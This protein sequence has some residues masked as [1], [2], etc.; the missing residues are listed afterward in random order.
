MPRKQYADEGWSSEKRAKRQWLLWGRSPRRLVVV[1]LL[2]TTLAASLG[3]SWLIQGIKGFKDL[4]GPHQQW[5]GVVVEHHEGTLVFT[6]FALRYSLVVGFI[7]QH[8][9]SATFTVNVDADTFDAVP[10]GMLITLDL[11]PQT[12]HVYA[13]ATS[14]NGITWT[15]QPLD[16][17]GNQLRLISWVLVPSGA[18]LLLLGL[19]GLVLGLVGLIDFLGGT[20]TIIGIVIDVVEGSFFRMPCVIVDQ[21]DGV[22][23]VLPLRPVVYE[24]VCEDGGRSQMTFIVSRRLR[25]VRRARRKRASGVIPL[26]SEKPSRQNQDDWSRPEEQQE[27]VQSRPA[28]RPAIA[29]QVVWEPYNSAVAWQ[30]DQQSAQEIP[31]SAVPPSPTSRQPS[32]ESRQQPSY[33][34]EQHPQLGRIIRQVEPPVTPP[35]RREGQEEPPLYQGGR[36]PV[37]PGRAAPPVSM[38]RGQTPP[39]RRQEQPQQREEYF[40]QQNRWPQ[41]DERSDIEAWRLWRD[42]LRQD[43]ENNPMKRPRPQK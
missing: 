31:I 28:G 19:V 13:L 36:P 15:R 39:Q 22:P 10:D 33:R 5:H 25:N 7:D 32:S 24:K 4:A 43:Y 1:G 12:G 35:Q 17:G 26:K 29:P 20:E 21:G 6:N 11:G 38:E 27:R 18:L 41:E 34:Q 16:S 37:P 40:P 2:L 9:P 42:Q 8:N 14:S 23:V 30:R 3:V